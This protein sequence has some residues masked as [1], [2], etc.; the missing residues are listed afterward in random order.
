MRAGL[1]GVAAGIVEEHQIAGLQLRDGIDS[2]ADA[3]LPLAGSGMGQGVAELLV[4]IHGKA[5][6]VKTAG[7]G[8]AV[9]ITGAK[10]LHGGIHDGIAGGGRSGVGSGQIQEIAADIAF[11]AVFAGDIIPAVFE[12]VDGDDGAAVHAG[13]DLGFRGGAGANVDAVAIGAAIGGEDVVLINDQIV[14]GDVAGLAVVSDPVP[15]VDAVVQHGHSHTL[16]QGGDNRGRSGGLFPKSQRGAG[17]GAHGNGLF[18]LSRRSKARQ[19]Q[20]RDG[21]EQEHAGHLTCEV[22]HGCTSFR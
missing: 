10:M 14:G 12:A 9:D 3:A 6:A 13:Q 4:N 16:V 1:A 11:R 17:G 2:G 20:Y 8:T 18:R 22:C 21:R 19:Q 15:T 5:G 7:G